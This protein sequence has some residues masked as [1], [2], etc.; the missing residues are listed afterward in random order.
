[1]GWTNEE[2]RKLKELYGK[3]STAGQIAAII[4]KTRNSIIGKSFRLKLST[5]SNPK[6]NN[7]KQIL[8]HQENT[9]L[10]RTKT[11]KSKFISTLIGK[12]FP[13]ERKVT[14]EQLRNEDCRFPNG[15]PDQPYPEFNFCGRPSVKGLS[16]C[17]AHLPL[18]FQPRNKKEELLNKEDDL[19]KFI[20]K[21]IKSA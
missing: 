9:S 10:S 7:S 4:G 5:K 17:L 11:R 2:V 8:K 15:H 16:Y 20:G 13:P 19:Q 21:K 18:V 3:G 12:D 14:L 1:M 6:S